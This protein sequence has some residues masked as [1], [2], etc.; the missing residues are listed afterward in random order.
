[1]KIVLFANTDWYL[2]NF[3]L[4]LARAL[5]EAGHEV[6]LVSP[7]GRYGP[8]FRNLDFRWVAAPMERRSL[9]PVRE[10]RLL[11]WLR[12]LFVA[13]RVDLVHSFTIKCA[14]YGSL[15]SFLPLGAGVRASR[16]NAVAGMGY[17]FTSDSLRARALRPLV[18]VL[19]R[20]ALGGRASRLIVQNSEDAEFFGVAGIVRR[21]YIRV[22]PGSGVDCKEFIPSTR[23]FAPD[24][25]RHFRVVLPA[26]L[27]WDKGVSE[28]IDAA[29]MLIASGR[30]IDFLLAGD[31]D[32]GNPASISA[33]VLENWVRDGVV[34]WLGQVNDMPELFRS[35]DLVVLPSYREGLPKGLIEA[36]ACGI[37]V[38]TT[39]VPGCRDVVS[40]GVDGL[41]VPPKNPV[42]LARAIAHLQD[43]PQ[44][45]RSYGD[46][47]RLKVLRQFD[48]RIVIASTFN[49]YEEMV[50]GRIADK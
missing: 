8:M 4:S 38:V 34:K 19:F 45:R 20:L 12:R 5:R 44:E 16:V 22:I 30:K 42:Q 28:Y 43:N 24:P 13:E 18:K 27:L 50:R 25:A 14:I 31:R 15:A 39:D 40:D 37:P 32:E 48:E 2:F 7:P 1:M 21:D 33:S 47:L 26:R 46:A 36:G 6:L 17:V 10:I 49:V 11:W 9:N 3:R 41:L 29:R 23:P 35:V